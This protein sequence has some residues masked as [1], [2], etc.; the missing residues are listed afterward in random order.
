MDIYSESGRSMQSERGNGEEEN[1]GKWLPPLLFP[2]VKQANKRDHRKQLT[3]LNEKRE[4]A[5]SRA[6]VVCQSLVL[7][8]AFLHSPYLLGEGPKMG[9]I[10]SLPEGKGRGRGSEFP[11]EVSPH[12]TDPILSQKKANS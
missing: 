3:L 2:K 4:T 7:F 8:G 12:Q 1:V 9:T 6:I 11:F 10:P 5:L